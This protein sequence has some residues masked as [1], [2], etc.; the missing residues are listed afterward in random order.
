[1]DI[2][3]TSGVIGGQGAFGYAIYVREDQ[4]DRAASALE[5]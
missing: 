1:V 3:A 2:Y 5:V 4:F